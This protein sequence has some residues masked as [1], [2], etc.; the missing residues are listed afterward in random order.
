M[1]AFWSKLLNVPTEPEPQPYKD[2]VFLIGLMRSGTTM[3][4]N[5]LS[6]HPQLLKVGFELNG[7]W[8]KIGGAPCSV[9][10]VERTEAHFKQEYANNMTAYFSNYLAESKKPIRHLARWS[11]K[12]FYG[13]GRVFYDW[14]DIYLLNKSPHLSNKIRYVHSIYPNAKFIVLIRDIH[15]QSASLKKHFEYHHRNE[16]WYFELPNGDS[17]CWTNHKNPNVKELDMSR[18]FPPEFNVIPESWVRLHEV[19]L[20]HL[21]A[22]PDQN[23][24]FLSY[25]NL[26]LNQSEVLNKVF[27]FL[28]LKVEH[29]AEMDKRLSKNRK[30]H[31]T[32]TKGNPLEKWKTHL[33]ADEINMIDQLKTEHESL[34]KRIELKLQE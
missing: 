30:V 6:E 26:V 29:Q 5:I 12:R 27:Q 4:M 8:T 18:V 22:V 11:A 25:E 21:D 32:S 24:I 15:G 2:P 23:K 17:D 10:C 34:I 7:I 19:M 28:S 14:D 31:N 9:G 13:S 33:S 3:L 16:N 20:N 1:C